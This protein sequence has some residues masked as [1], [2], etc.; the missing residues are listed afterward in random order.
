MN[1]VVVAVVAVV[2]KII[3]CDVRSFNKI[4]EKHLF[5]ISFSNEECLHLCMH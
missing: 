5:I 1:V 4:I 3:K 2:M